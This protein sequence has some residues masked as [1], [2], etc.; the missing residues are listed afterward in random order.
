MADAGDLASWFRIACR[1]KI[2]STDSL[3]RVDAGVGLVL[4]GRRRRGRAM[5]KS[6]LRA[7]QRGVLEDAAERQNRKIT[8]DRLIAQFGGAFGFVWRRKGRFGNVANE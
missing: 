5:R 7:G 4:L 6:V 2:S 3:E 1:R 8:F